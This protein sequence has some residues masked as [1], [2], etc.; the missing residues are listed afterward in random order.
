MPTQ[1]HRPS[2][3]KCS[4]CFHPR[5]Q[6]IDDDILHSGLSLMQL[7]R[8]WGM[9]AMRFRNHKLKHLLP[10]LK[11]A[12]MA[13]DKELVPATP[14]TIGESQSPAVGAPQVIDDLQ[15]LHRKRADFLYQMAEKVLRDA[16]EAGDSKKVLEAIKIATP[17]LAEAR[18][19]I[20][21]KGRATGEL[22]T[23]GTGTTVSGDKVVVIL[24]RS[25]DPIPGDLLN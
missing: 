2:G 8:K 13:L 20:E 21:L 12:G 10:A 1:S 25:A 11:M 22:K 17:L 3:P 6:E 15:Q 23:P 19:Y 4:I 24:P 16:E 14:R 18:Q 9:T 5:H 7:E